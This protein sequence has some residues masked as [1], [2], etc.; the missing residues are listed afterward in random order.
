MMKKMLSCKQIP[1]FLLSALFCVACASGAN[2]SS[3][4]IDHTYSVLLYE[5]PDC[6]TITS[7]NPVKVERGESASFDIKLNNG[8][9]I[10]HL[11][12]QDEV[13]EAA[14]KTNVSNVT[15]ITI[16]NIRYSASF[17]LECYDEIY[18][19]SYYPNG[20]EY[21][22]IGYSDAPYQE[23][24]SQKNRLRPN[25]DIGTNRIQRDGYVLNGWN[26]RSDG[27]GERVGLGSRVSVNEDNTLHLYAMWEK[28]SPTSDFEFLLT[29]NGYSVSKYLGTVSKAVVPSRYNDKAVVGI[30]TGAF[31][32]NEEIVIL[33]SSIA[34]IDEGAFSNSKIQELYLYDNVQDVSDSS[35]RDCVDFSTVHFNAILAP[36]FGKDNLYSEINL[37]DKY[38]ILITNK[39]KKKIVA[40][41]GSG[42]FI[43]LD[44]SLMEKAC[45]NDA[46]CINM[47]MNGW[48]N[49]AAQYEMMMP[50]LNAGDTF[51]HV[52]ETSSQF[53]AMYN[54]TMIPEI[55]TFTY[56]KLRFFS[57]LESNLD[58]LSLVDVRH[59]EDF[60]TGFKEFNE[61]RFPLKET[62]Y[63]DYK[64]EIT[65][66]G[67]KYQNDF[68]YIDNR[69]NWALDKEAKEGLDEAGEADIV[70]EY[71]IDPVARQRLNGYFTSLRDRGVN[72]YF[73]N[74]GINR[75]TLEKRLTDPHSFDGKDNGHLYYGRPE[76]IPEPDYPSI[77]AWVEDY[78]KAVRDYL[79]V[80][81]LVPL[82]DVLYRTED[83]FEPDYHLASAA[84][85][86]YTK[87]FIDA[88]EKKGAL[89]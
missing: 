16:P 81:V 52:P 71:V 18:T 58:L 26:T 53:G 32:G 19:I 22:D 9:A 86:A 78:Q 7:A 61:Y 36:R 4:S 8:I 17:S 89:E 31:Y 51:L 15:T 46:V 87:L 30:E 80:E 12:H 37:A 1:V 54:V 85:E 3:G 56:N 50:Y 77:E 33:P 27:S 11:K 38:D 72:V 48:F 65:I 88:L 79:D 45:K 66:Y 60:F 59:V 42:A 40:F 57:A 64:T 83:Y 25:T 20:G 21:L 67:K 2:S 47:A 13:V 10:H 73:G 76:G 49:G 41:G 63:E 84:S 44:T 35:F 62:T 39:D 82:E 29:D 34:Y 14:Y 23:R 24:Y 43:S 75:D 5:N 74:A 69:G 70:L 6:Y 68:G 55:G 28:E